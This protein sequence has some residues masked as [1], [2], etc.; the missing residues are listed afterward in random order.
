M[1]RLKT[2]IAQL[3]SLIGVQWWKVN[4]D[5][6]LIYQPKRKQMVDCDEVIFNDKQIANRMRISLWC[7]RG[8][9]ERNIAKEPENNR[10]ILLNLCFD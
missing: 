8:E 4:I 6:Q 1:K 3:H 10:E 9:I 5:M 2:K 7:F